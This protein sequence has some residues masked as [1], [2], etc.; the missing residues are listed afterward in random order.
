[1]TS[2]FHISFAEINQG[3][4]TQLYVFVFDE[5]FKFLR[6]LGTP[7]DLRPYYDNGVSIVHLCFVHGKEEILFVDSR[8]Q[9]RIFSLVS[10]QPKYFFF[11]LTSHVLL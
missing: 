3:S 10:L 2:R 11:F 7:I 4:Q 1:M 9:A 8:A 5:D 6:G